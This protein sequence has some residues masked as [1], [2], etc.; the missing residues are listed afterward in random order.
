MN[1]DKKG[2]SVAP[3]VRYVNLRTVYGAVLSRDE[4]AQRLNEKRDTINAQIEEDR[5]LLL[6]DGVDR[7]EVSRRLGSARRKLLELA[8]DEESHKARLLN[9]IQ[10][11]IKNV[12]E[13][14][15]ADF[16]LNGGDDVLYGKKRYDITE[17][18]IREL[19]RIETRSDPVSR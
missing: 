10:T 7:D 17:D 15:G 18:V 19:E 9:R 1:R 6:L 2:D 16:V 11:A 8:D 3:V 4:K 5:R 13:S 12:A 14:I